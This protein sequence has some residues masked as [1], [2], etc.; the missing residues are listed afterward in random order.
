MNAK[1]EYIP[2][3]EPGAQCLDDWLDGWEFAT[4]GFVMG[5]VVEKG[6]TE[7]YEKF[8]VRM[9]NLFPRGLVGG[10]PSRMAAQV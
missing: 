9:A 7:A 10:L 4:A 5:A 8:F 1:G 3:E 6:L 2:R